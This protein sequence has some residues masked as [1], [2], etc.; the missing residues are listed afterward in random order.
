MGAASGCASDKHHIKY[1]ISCTGTSGICMLQPAATG[2]Q[3]L[4]VVFA[5]TWSARVFAEST[6]T[7]VYIYWGSER[8]G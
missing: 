7:A 4:K 1:H 2:G 3:Q 6:H 8:G 5:E